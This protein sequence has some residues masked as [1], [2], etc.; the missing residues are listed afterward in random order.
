M[1]KNITVP[2]SIFE[3]LRRLFPEKD[4]VEITATVAGDNCVSRFLVALNV[5]ERNGV[6]L[7]AREQ[8]C[9]DIN[10]LMNI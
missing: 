6:G 5:G 3:E 4:T 9:E 8:C 10:Q 2:E 7:P 1:T